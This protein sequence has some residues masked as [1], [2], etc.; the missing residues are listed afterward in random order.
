[1]KNQLS[2]V[3]NLVLKTVFAGFYVQKRYGNAG[4]SHQRILAVVNI[5]WNPAS[6][7][8]SINSLF[9]RPRKTACS[10]PSLIRGRRGSK[11][12]AKIMEHTRQ[13]NQCIKVP[14]YNA[15]TNTNT[16]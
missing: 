12:C 5:G 15:L 7:T 16:I 14:E 13:S 3:V 11:P 4:K 2:L 9:R 6:H 10:S 8:E 1:M